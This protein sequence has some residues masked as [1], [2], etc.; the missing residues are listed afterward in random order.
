MRKK[1]GETFFGATEAKIGPGTDVKN[2]HFCRKFFGKMKR[3][4]EK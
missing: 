4:F 2:M 1:C 3:N